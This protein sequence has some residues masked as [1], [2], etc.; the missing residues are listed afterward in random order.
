MIT[1]LTTITSVHTKLQ[2]YNKTII[3]KQKQNIHSIYFAIY[4]FYCNFAPG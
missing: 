3:L 1:S 4:T 2:Q